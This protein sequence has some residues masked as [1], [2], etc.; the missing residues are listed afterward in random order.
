VDK[1]AVLLVC[2]LAMACGGLASAQEA[3]NAWSQWK[4]MPQG[5]DFFP[6]G[7]WAQNSR[8]AARYKALGVDY[9][10]ALFGGPTEA[11]VTDLR[12]A[13]IA[14][15]CS[16]NDYAR[17]NLLN[18]PLVWGWMHGDEPDLA[19]VYSRDKLKGPNGK[20]II[21]EHWPEVYKKLDLDHNEYNGWGMGANPVDIQA[22]YKRWKRADPTRPVLLQLSNSVAFDGKKR[23]R[24]DHNGNIEVYPGYIAGADIV[25]FDVYPVANGIPNELWRVSKGLDQIREWGAA[26]KPI[27]VILEAG[28]GEK[29]ADHHQQRAQAWL[30][31]NHGASSLTWF[32][33]RW[34]TVD[35]QRKLTST[36]MPLT[37]AEVGKAVKAINDEVHS[38]A[39]VINSPAI[40]D[41]MEV[42]GAALDLSARRKDGAIYVFAVE[43][44]GE[45][46]KGGLETT[47]KL[48][49]V[50]A[51]N[52]E[53]I[54]EDRKL[55]C[56]GGA[57]TDAF[58]AWDVHLYKLTPK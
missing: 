19:H 16:M 28:F 4:V 39:A 2:V 21:K 41:G 22:D 52:V 38:L 54:G 43:K 20:Q 49:G 45:P 26:K 44:A 33:H 11:Q 57:F 42:E 58:A 51:A 50:G 6:I 47:I 55:A 7:V 32:C 53:V 17:K 29:W 46:G 25:S 35:G 12:K 40:T 18:D 10:L 13:G 1:T 30:G 27:M 15:I 23:G 34:A 8:R 31:I 48:K 24:G 5:E 36:A 3:K 37:D 14:T 9:Y 56:T